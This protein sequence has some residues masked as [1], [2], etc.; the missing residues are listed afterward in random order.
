MLTPPRLNSIALAIVGTLVFW[1]LNLPL[2]FLFGPMCASLIGALAGLQLKTLG[3]IS[4][5]ARTILGVAVGASVTPALL[6]KL[7]DMAITLAIIPLY[8]A[9]IGAIGVPFFTRF[10][11]FDRA[12]AY[13]SAMPGGLQDMIIFG[14]EAGGDARTLSLVHATRVLIII[15]VA[16]LFLTTF[17]GASLSNP[18]G[19]PA[20][21]IPI[22]QILLMIIIAIVGWKGGERLGLFGASI[23]GPLLLGA[24]LSL[25]GVLQSRPP[26]EA[27]LAAQ[28]FIGMG[29]GVSYAGVTLRELRKTVL[30]GIAFVLILAL[31]AAIVTAA[32]VYL[33]LAPGLEGFLAFAPGGQAEMTVLALVVGADLGFVVIHHLMRILVVI[34]GAPVAARLVL[35]PDTARK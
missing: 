23:M 14:Q 22:S 12:T 11:G 3:P 17:F 5:G 4:A 10:C 8:I 20:S 25:A 33:G 28:F 32:V 34:L 2:P 19:A 24:A 1:L 7:P 35:N 15:S 21:E 16:P 18:I 31:L 29:I 27:I 26:S 6:T 13:Y 30:S 9:V